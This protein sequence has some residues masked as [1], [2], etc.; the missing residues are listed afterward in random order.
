MP[1]L[2][3]LVAG[4]YSDGRTLLGSVRKWVAMERPLHAVSMAYD[5]F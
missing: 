2:V 4:V 1:W 3:A 5:V